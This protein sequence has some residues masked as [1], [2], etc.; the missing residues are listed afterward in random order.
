MKKLSYKLLITVGLLI[1]AMTVSAATISIQD[2]SGNADIQTAIGQ[3]ESEL[4]G[5]G[6]QIAFLGDDKD[7]A[8]GM[9]DAAHY[10]I[11]TANA[12]SFQGYDLFSVTFG[13]G[14]GAVYTIGEKPQDL[15]D[16]YKEEGD[17]SLGAGGTFAANFGLNLGI[18]GLE[19]FYVNLLIGG[20][21]EVE[22][23]DFKAKQ[24]NYG[25]GM[26]YTLIQQKR[27]LGG[28]AGWRGLALS[29]GIYRTNA[30][31]KYT[32]KL[33]KIT[34][35]VNSQTVEFDPTAEIESE[36]SSTI[37]PFDISTSFQ[38]LWILNLGV[39]VGADLAFGKSDLN[40]NATADAYSTTLQ[41]NVGK[42]KFDNDDSSSKIS[43]FTPKVTGSLGFNFGPLKVDVPV[44]WYP[45]SGYFVG[46]TVGIVW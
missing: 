24:Y 16:K 31:T 34:Q 10:T 6:S 21:P 36:I 1:P 44:A 4:N 43:T 14:A 20:I 2:T 45:T 11:L 13:A 19:N 37:I 25:L 46:A 8:K 30:F 28:L 35:T 23:Q 18:F 40:V 17:I 5:A 22:Y 3:V 26:T 42:A 32:V 38:F 29:T 41:Q 9:G 7:L 27:V 39:G 33:D 15:Q 12:N